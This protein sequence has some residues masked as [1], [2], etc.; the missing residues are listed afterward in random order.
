MK[1]Q[2]MV[3]YSIDEGIELLTKNSKSAKEK[4]EYLD[5][6][7]EFIQ[8]QVVIVQVSMARIH[9]WSV[10]NKRKVKEIK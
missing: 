2:L 8:E 5:R 10:V 1:A 3:E 9:N 7:I 4:V 6:C